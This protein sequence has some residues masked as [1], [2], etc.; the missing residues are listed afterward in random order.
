MKTAIKKVN[1]YYGVIIPND[2]I[3]VTGE[4]P[5]WI[6]PGYGIT[7]R[8]LDAAD[9]AILHLRN[10]GKVFKYYEVGEKDY[11]DSIS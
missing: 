9:L 2:A 7:Y 6:P 11:E 8:I 5:K 3:G 10:P 1:R 4:N